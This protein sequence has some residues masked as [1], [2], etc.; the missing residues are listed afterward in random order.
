MPDSTCSSSTSAR[1]A[2]IS[3]RGGTV[4]FLYG[5]PAAVRLLVAQTPELE[6]N[7]Q[8]ILKKLAGAGTHVEEATVRGVPGLLPEW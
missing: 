2:S 5:R 6:I 4:W 3:G 8:F 1:I 7:E